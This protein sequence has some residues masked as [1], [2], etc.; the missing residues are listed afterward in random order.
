MTTGAIV[1]TFG[2]QANSKVSGQILDLNP[3]TNANNDIIWVC[4]LASVPA[5]VSAAGTVVA[6]TNVSAQYLPASCHA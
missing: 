4:G 2:V 3:Y 1:V 5:N 6:S